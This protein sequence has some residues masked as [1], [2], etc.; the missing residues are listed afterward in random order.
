M[1]HHGHQGPGPQ[2]QQGAARHTHPHHGHQQGDTAAANCLIL[3]RYSR[4]QEYIFWCM[5]YA[6]IGKCRTCICRKERGERRWRIEDLR[7]LDLD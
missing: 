5:Q 6:L 4:W 2:E 1:L 3:V 7:I